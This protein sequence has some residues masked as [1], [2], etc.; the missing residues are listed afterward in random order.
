LYECLNE[1]KDIWR[2]QY[3]IE[4]N[5]I[6]IYLPSVGRSDIVDIVYFSSPPIAHASG[7]TFSSPWVPRLRPG[8]TIRIDPKYFRQTFEG[9]QIQYQKDG[10]MIAQMIDVNFNTVTNQNQMTVMAL[11]TAEVVQR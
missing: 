3:A 6:N 5:V 2:F 8:M 7:I 1:L 10:L 4:G 9:K 11:N